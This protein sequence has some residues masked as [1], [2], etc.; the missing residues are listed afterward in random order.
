MA[1]LTSPQAR[2]VMFQAVALS[3]GFTMIIVAVAIGTFVCSTFIMPVGMFLIVLMMILEGTV[4]V[5]AFL[6]ARRLQAEY[7]SQDGGAANAAR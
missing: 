5:P 2:K 7:D 6:K 3:A 4:V 1:E